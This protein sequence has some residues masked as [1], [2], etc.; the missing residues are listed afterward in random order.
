[1]IS[2]HVAAL[3]RVAHLLA[4]TEDAAGTMAAVVDEGIRVFGAHRAG[5]FLLDE[6]TG[7]AHAQIAVGLSPAYLAEVLSHYRE[8]HA[9]GSAIRGAAYFAEDARADVTSP[10]H[11]TVQAEGFAGVAALPLSYGGRVIGWLAFYHDVPRVYAASER[12]LAMAFADLSAL[13]I[14]RSRLADTMVRVKQEWQ[15]AF[16]G[17]GNGLA[18]VDAQGR[19]ERANRFIADLAGVSVT[20]LPGL[21]LDRVFP[22]WADAGDPLGDA[23]RSGQRISRFLDT[24]RGRHA[25]LSVT[26][27]G[28]GGFVLAVDDVTHYVRLESRY[29]Q[30]VATALEAILLA[31]PAGQV[32]MA[33]PAAGELFGRPPSDLVGQPLG[34]LLPD[35]ATEATE[36]A[37][38]TPR[39]HEVLIRRRD[40]VRIAD[41]SV[42]ELEE[43]GTPAGRVVV[44]RDVTR[45]R[46]A[47]EALRRSERRFRALFNRAPLA[48]FTLDREGRFLSANRAAIRMA[49]V[50]AP[51]AAA[52]LGSFVV[53]GEWPQVAAELARSFRGETRDFMFHFR[54]ADDVLRQASAV[55]VP[56]EE[57]GGL[58]AVLA[59]ARDVTEEVE[60]RERLTHSEKMAAL[61]ALVSGVAHELNNP[62]AGIAAMA[63]ALRFDPGDPEDL[64]RGLETVQQE[65]MRAARIVTDLLGFARQRPL[66]RRDANLNVLIRE[67]FATTPALA[68]PGTIWTLGLDPTLPAVSADPDQVRQVITN[69]L[70]NAAQAMEGRDARQGLVRTWSTRDWVGFEVLDSGP[71]IPPEVLSRIFEPFFT[72]KPQGKGTGLG[73]S[74]SHGIIRAH[75][76]EITGGNR[77]EGGA[78]FALQLPRDPTRIARSPHA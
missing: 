52:W 13:A 27:R 22:G 10:I 19:I 23:R 67:T 47:T 59:I 61:G 75:G 53:S 35:E 16:D 43:R 21:P 41:V 68:A 36:A 38:E 54:R 65:A 1:M 57:R 50:A 34:A 7:Q 37:G 64:S 51:T 69:L 15:A 72:T 56:V 44:A 45:E 42:A 9:A 39:R 31:D 77:P 30:L 40:G 66:D 48:I 33:N 71:G 14:G 25:V 20:E 70:V 46:L 73:L 8:T 55:I 29:S 11:R 28:A 17:I 78:R 4:G 5:L 2:S 74:L 62:L 49:A 18:L 32:V 58:R 60:L 6:H 76:G 63:Q 26:P 24:L 12:T 3:G